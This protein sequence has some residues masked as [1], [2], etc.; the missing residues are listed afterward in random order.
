V[1]SERGGIITGWLFRLL[2]LFAVAGLC[3][4]EAGAI[5][6]NKV[7]TDSI[8]IDAAGAAADEYDRIGSSSKAKRECASVAEGRGATCVSL[9]VSGG[10]LTVV[11][12]RDAPTLVTHLIGP[13]EDQTV[14][15]AEHSAPV[16]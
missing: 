6:V 3:L 1:T 16:N 12:V 9:K 2:F 5:I 8:A 10:R 15:T 7:Q 14:A 4:F 13:L 11:V